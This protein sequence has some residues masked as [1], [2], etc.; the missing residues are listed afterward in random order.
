MKNNILRL[1]LYYRLSRD[2]DKE[3]NSLNNQRSILVDYAN[4]ND[5]EIVGESFD[6]NITGMHFQRQGIDELQDAA[7]K[8]LMDAVL[9]KDLSRLGRHKTMTAIFIENLRQYKVKVISVTEN[10]DTSNEND[11]LIIGFKQLLNDQYSRDISR[12]IRWGFKQ[13]QKEG[14]VIVA[15]FGYRKDKNTNTIEVVDECAE[16]VRLIFN[17]YINGMGV[18]K[19]ATYL[20]DR[21]Y[22]S[23]AYYQKLYYN[24]SVPF[25]K[26]KIGKQYIWSDKGVTNILINEAYVGT[27]IC[28]KTT[29]STIYKTRE[30]TAEDQQI[31][32]ENFYVPI[33][34]DEIWKAACS[35]KKHRETVPVRAGNQKIHRYA[36]F[37]KCAECGGSF[38]SKKR[39]FENKEY[40]EYICTTYNRH[41]N[42][43]CSSHRIREQDIDDLLYAEMS[44]IKN[45]ASENLKKVDEF[46]K[47]W[48]NQRNDH[49]QLIGKF[50]MQETELAENIKSLIL[51]QTRNPQ[52]AVFIEEVIKDCEKQMAEIK[53][54]ITQLKSSDNI[55]RNARQNIKNAIE[56]LEEIILSK[57]IDNSHLHM[58][59]Y[60]IVVTQPDG[61]E[62]IDLEFDL[63]MPLKSHTVMNNLMVAGLTEGD[64]KITEPN[65]S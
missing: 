39:V 55:E 31:R 12:K 16:I 49:E 14:I 11:E 20:N 42:K 57:A 40:V 5:Y 56:T 62:N 28:G 52:R 3:L 34:S 22:K 41:G 29:K 19:I 1:W 2:E 7:E 18:R 25:N 17:L 46:I 21:G 27:L 50:Q 58:V 48:T 8:R 61:G 59:L 32:H 24:K 53:G 47:V 9:V 30:Y 23:P 54:K 45:L 60:N 64:N 63:K 51:E 43:Y 36:G 37:L 10:I 65:A 35:I 6:D 15:P 33:I 44:K 26:T 13:K 4:R 38:T